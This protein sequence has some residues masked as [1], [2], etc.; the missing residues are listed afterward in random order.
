MKYWEIIADKLSKPDWSWGYCSAVMRNGRRS[1][2]P[3]RKK[4]LALIP[5]PEQALPILAVIPLVARL[6][7][8]EAAG[9]R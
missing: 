7:R 4:R 6:M 9:A 1:A 5:V 2:L 8:L 3:R